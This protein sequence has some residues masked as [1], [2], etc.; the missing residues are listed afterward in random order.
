MIHTSEVTKRFSTLCA[1]ITL[2]GVTLFVL[3]IGLVVVAA[4]L[5]ANSLGLP[6]Q[7]PPPAPSGQ[8]GGMAG[9]TGNAYASRFAG[10]DCG[11]KINAA[12]AWLGSL[13]GEIW[14]DR[15]CGTVW[16]TN[17][18]FSGSRVLRFVQGGTYKV[19]KIVVPPG[20]NRLSMIASG[21][22]MTVLQAASPNAP[23]IQCVQTG[24]A[25]D[26]DYFSGFSVQAHPAGS[27]GP[28]IDLSGCRGSVFENISYLSNGSANFGS[29]F[30][31]SASPAYCYSNRIA[32]Q[33]K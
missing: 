14:I 5:G 6:P 12:D 4:L 9:E 13:P 17:L 18:R 31:L 20:P 27:S 7:G 8:A 2:L 19:P 25:S 11:A 26:G 23:V 3:G 22:G 21:V 16:T 10:N 1:E 15:A 28:A 30:R 32:H 33:L 24:G 29:F